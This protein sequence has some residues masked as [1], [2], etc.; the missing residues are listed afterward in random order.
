MRIISGAYK[1]RRFDVP[2][3]FKARPTTDFAKEN[4]FNVIRNL[5][6]LE[7]TSALDLFAGTGSISFELIS[8]G[9]REVVCVEK[10]TV[11]YAFIKKVKDELK[12]DQLLAVKTDAMKYI[13]SVDRTFDFIFADPPYA[14]KELPQIPEYILLR[15]LL[16]PNGIFVME[17]PKE[18]DF[19]HL[20]GF[21]QRRVYGSVNFSI[22]IFEK[23]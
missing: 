14:F 11:H 21:S 4:I 12:A 5:I 3:N 10:D 15:N 18:Y 9:C 2:K 23:K 13:T 16:N 20:P 22:F 8:R 7:G 1:S 19:S 17:H 6:D